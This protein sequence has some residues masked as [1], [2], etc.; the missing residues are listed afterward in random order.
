MQRLIILSVLALVAVVLCFAASTEKTPLTMANDSSDPGEVW[1]SVDNAKTDNGIEAEVQINSLSSPDGSQ[2][3]KATNFAFSIPGGHSIEGIEVRIQ[4]LEGDLGTEQCTDDS[5]KLVKGGVIGGDDKPDT[6]GWTTS[7][8]E[9]TYGSSGDKWGRTWL[10]ADINATN[11]GVVISVIDSVGDDTDEDCLIDVFKIT[12]FHIGGKKL[13]IT[14][15]SREAKIVRV[16][17]I[18]A[19]HR[20]GC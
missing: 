15:Q 16:S 12:V 1:L 7:E 18:E 13:L 4:R 6:G 14:K 20:R 5:V 10:P 2:F 19:L 3:L 17:S 8:V 9:I 11:F